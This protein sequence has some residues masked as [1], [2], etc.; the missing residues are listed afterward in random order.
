[1]I[2]TEKSITSYHYLGFQLSREG[3]FLEIFDDKG[4]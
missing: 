1:M 3:D 2:K 4:F